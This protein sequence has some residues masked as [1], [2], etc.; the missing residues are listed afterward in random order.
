MSDD[1]NFDELN[2]RMTALV[3]RREALTRGVVEHDFIADEAHEHWS[4]DGVDFFIRE[5]RAWSELVEVHRLGLTRD[6]RLS[7]GRWNGYAR[8]AK[9]PGLIPGTGG[10]YA[11][12]PVHGGITFFQEWANEHVPATKRKR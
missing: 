3:A 2:E 7:F 1:D 8:F 5:N 11:Y 10:I 6:P 12:V 9:L 4:K